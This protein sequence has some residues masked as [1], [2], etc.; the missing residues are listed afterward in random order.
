MRPAGRSSRSAWIAAAGAAPWV[1]ALTGAPARGQVISDEPPVELRGVEIVERR[2]EQVP[3]DLTLRDSRGRALR[4]G[5]YFDG[6][7]PVV[8]VMAYYTCPM[9]CQLVLSQTLEALK[10]LDWT[11]GK[12][13]RAL[14][15]SF[16]HRDTPER[17]AGWQAAMLAGYDRETVG[18]GWSFCVA[19]GATARRLGDALGFHYNFIREAGEFAHPSAIMILSPEGAVAN[20]I[21][22]VK[23]PAA[24]VKL[25]LS[26]AADGKVGSIFDRIYARCF[27]YDPDRNSFVPSAMRIM[28]IGG[29]LTV[30]ALAALVGGLLLFT[31]RRAVAGRAPAS[32]ELAP[33][34][35]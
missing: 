1:C 8:L 4:I 2:G 21:Y 16:D 23:Y 12:E 22:G 25:A 31:R 11:L 17:A 9:Q 10:D 26:Q 24:Q 14:T 5:D 30:V 18:E 15:V 35:A 19:D 27:I 34:P 29:A 28:R 3:P 33:A 32:E 6:E 20:Y 13:Y 7:R